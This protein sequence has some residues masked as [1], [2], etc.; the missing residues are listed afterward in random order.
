MKMPQ[1]SE[2]QHF[3]VMSHCATIS[4]C[5]NYHQMLSYYNNLKN[6]KGILA[7]SCAVCEMILAF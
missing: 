6:I 7:C 5:T 4:V 3:N 2:I 1:T